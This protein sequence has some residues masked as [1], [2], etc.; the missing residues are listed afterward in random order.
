MI[1][2]VTQFSVPSMPENRNALRL[3]PRAFDSPNMEGQVH[4]TRGIK[5]LGQPTDLQLARAGRAACR[6]PQAARIWLK[7]TQCHVCQYPL[8]FRQERV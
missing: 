7:A 4:V 3:S 8:S 6:R 5:R 2:R 1:G